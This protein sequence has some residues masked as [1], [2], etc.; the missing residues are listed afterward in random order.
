ML[1]VMNGHVDCVHLLL[2]KGA[3]VDAGDK[4]GRTT[5]HRA[6]SSIFK[7]KE[8]TSLFL[9]PPL[10]LGTNMVCFAPFVVCNRL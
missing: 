2:E 1:A 8:E 9:L 4:R 7:L 3:T 6:V 10:I 5:L